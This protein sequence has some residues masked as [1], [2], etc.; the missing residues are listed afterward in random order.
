MNRSALFSC[1]RA[2]RLIVEREHHALPRGEL[3]QLRVHLLMCRWCRRF[4]T[5]M[6]WLS[7]AIRKLS[8]PPAPSEIR[9][10]D[11]ARRRMRDAMRQRPPGSGKF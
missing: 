6:R 7:R 1:E 4:L 5:Q 2:T 3:S 10:S 9:L 11:A 8:D